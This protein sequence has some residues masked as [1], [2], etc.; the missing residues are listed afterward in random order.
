VNDG[1]EGRLEEEG[2][3]ADSLREKLGN[4]RIFEEV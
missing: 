1:E 3:E 4:G 2:R